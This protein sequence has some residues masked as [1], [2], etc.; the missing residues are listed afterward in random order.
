M[1]PVVVRWERKKLLKTARM[2]QPTNTALQPVMVVTISHTQEVAW[3]WI[4]WTKS[5]KSQL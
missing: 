1:A 4:F 2:G 3:G 5:A